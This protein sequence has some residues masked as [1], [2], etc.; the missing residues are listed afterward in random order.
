MTIEPFYAAA[1]SAL[2][3]CLIF[4]ILLYFIPSD[5]KIK[6]G[7]AGNINT[8]TIPVLMGIG[9]LLLAANPVLIY[10]GD[11]KRDWVQLILG[12][13]WI[14][15]IIIFILTIIAYN[16]A[17][18][19]IKNTQMDMYPHQ[20]PWIA[21]HPGGHLSHDPTHHG[22]HPHQQAVHP[23]HAHPQ[24]AHQGLH[25]HQPTAQHAHTHQHPAHPQPQHEMMTVECPQCAK[26]IEIPVGSHTI[27]CPYCGLSGS[28]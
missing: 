25:P 5:K 11:F 1:E 13:L 19:V 24:P 9:G 28:M 3:T 17:K 20:E 16:H 6:E 14:L 23:V 21:P 4:F 10:L 2:A 12:G 7:R 27:T 15:M 26:H 8:P 18:K 22:G